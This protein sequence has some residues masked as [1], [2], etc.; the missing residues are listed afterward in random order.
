MF[1]ILCLI[2][3]NMIY[4]FC[5]VLRKGILKLDST[6]LKFELTLWDSWRANKKSN[7]NLLIHLSLV[8]WRWMDNET[9]SRLLHACFLKEIRDPSFEETF[10][11]FTYRHCTRCRW[12]YIINPI[13]RFVKLNI[14][15]FDGIFSCK[16]TWLFVCTIW[17]IFLECMV[18]IFQL[19]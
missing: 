3:C 6:V 19:L 16:M 9:K 1:N 10:I 15:Y 12:N 8:K 13:E 5:S 14:C 11:P 7:T 4:V 2:L 18:Q 17:M